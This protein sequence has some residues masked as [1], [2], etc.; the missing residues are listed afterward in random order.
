[1]TPELKAQIEARV[2]AT[3]NCWTVNNVEEVLTDRSALLDYAKLLEMTLDW[4]IK[5]PRTADPAFLEPP[6]HL[7]AVLEASRKRVAGEGI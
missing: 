1:M 4:V 5:D 3:A 2:D 7:V 6:S